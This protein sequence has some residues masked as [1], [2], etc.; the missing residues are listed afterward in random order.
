MKIG[1]ATILAAAI[2]FG[3]QPLSAQPVPEPDGYRG[4][5]YRAPV[6]ATLSGATVVTLADL[7]RLHAAGAVL[8]DPMPQLLRPENL[9]ADT[10]WRA[11]P[12]DTIPGAVWLP[13]TGYESLAARD[14]TAFATALAALSKGDKAHPL[15]F[16]CKADC[17]MS[18]NAARRAVAAGYTA[19][20]WFPRGVD[21]WT[22]AG[23]TLV[24]ATPYQP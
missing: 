17:W 23:R 3:A 18:W 8:I 21:D 13:G 1:A 5:P 22:E 10:I 6:P 19:V 7:D 2:A 24:T 20:S 12:H 16:F 14:E 15:V 11:R 4:E 9:P